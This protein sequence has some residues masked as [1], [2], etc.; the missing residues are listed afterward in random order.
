MKLA[1]QTYRT[2]LGPH[3]EAALEELLDRFRGLKGAPVRLVVLQPSESAAVDVVVICRYPRDLTWIWL[4]YDCLT[5]A[6][7]ELLRLR[8]HS[9][10]EAAR[11]CVVADLMREYLG[12]KPRRR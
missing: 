12:W 8:P 7:R 2:Q 4:T 3:A 10:N 9:M 11:D 6:K 5:P 1:W